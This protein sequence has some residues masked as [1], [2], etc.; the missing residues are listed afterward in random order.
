MASPD[1]IAPQRPLG[2]LS[3]R[4]RR[5]LPGGV[6][7][8]RGLSWM[9]PGSIP[10]GQQQLLT[11]RGRG[12]GPGAD[13]P[14]CHAEAATP[15]PTWSH[16]EP[17][18]G[19]PLVQGRQHSEK[20]WEKT[21]A[22]PELRAARSRGPA[23]GAG[24]CSFAGG[25]GRG[26]RGARGP[27]K[28]ESMASAAGDRARAQ[29]SPATYSA[30]P[31][32][33]PRS[34]VVSYAVAW[35][36]A[37]AAAPRGPAA[38][39]ALCGA[40][41]SGRGGAEWGRAERSGAVRSG[42]SPVSPRP[43]RAP[44]SRRPEGGAAGPAPTCPPGPSAQVRRPRPSRG[45]AARAQPVPAAGGACGGGTPPGSLRRAGLCAARRGAGPA[46]TAGLGWSGRG[47]VHL[48]PRVSVVALCS[49]WGPGWNRGATAGRARAGLGAPPRTGR[50]P[51]G[52]SWPV[53]CPR[54]QGPLLSR[55]SGP[56]REREVS[57]AAGELPPA[58]CRLPRAGVRS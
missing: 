37:C 6:Q 28:Q 35:L 7:R 18:R 26:R 25:S 43:P 24:G 8:P 32:E 12:G 15:G 14:C 47:G 19:L 54:P 52:P 51:R 55:I 27:F 3:G 36:R 17:S 10:Y 53:P 22:S 13:G 57:P 4:K 49:C 38:R 21:K 44:W 29:P 46:G 11:P 50:R 41:G 2:P 33:G 34:W 1:A 39:R 5:P 58:E 20:S 40:A 31:T 48:P 30:P 16:G 45:G 56:R 23:H 42:V 9:R